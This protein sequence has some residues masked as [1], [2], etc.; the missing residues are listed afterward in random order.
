M[1]KQTKKAPQE[2]F[3]KSLW[4]GRPH[5]VSPNP[6]TDKD[7]QSASEV[8]IYHGGKQHIVKEPDSTPAIPGQEPI[9]R[10]QSTPA[11]YAETF[12]VFY[13]N[14]KEK[15]DVSDAIENYKGDDLKKLHEFVKLYISL[16]PPL[17]ERIKRDI[18]LTLPDMPEV[19]GGDYVSG[20]HRLMLHCWKCKD[21]LLS[22]PKLLTLKEASQQYQPTEKTFRRWVKNDT[23]N[24]KSLRNH[25]QDPRKYLVSAAE[26]DSLGT[27]RTVPEV[28]I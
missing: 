26:I 3:I 13:K 4:L 14:L 27:V 24:G 16:I 8:L 23:G 28:D 10:V 7:R 18:G 9:E 15:W 20:I 1:Q 5:S 2:R 11:D 21:R 6:P 17:Q 22:K 12:S 19:I 25:S